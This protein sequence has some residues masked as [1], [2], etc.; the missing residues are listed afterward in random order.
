MSN[1]LTL[2]R[3]RIAEL[4]KRYKEL[5]IAASQDISTARSLLDPYEDPVTNIKIDE[6]K[7]VVNRLW[8][9]IKEM[10]SLETKI[11]AIKKDIGE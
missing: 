2:A 1:E 10:I 4:D 7:V 6:A 9:E 8:T 11:Q 5:D 3:G